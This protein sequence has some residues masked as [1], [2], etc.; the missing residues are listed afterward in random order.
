MNSGLLQFG[1]VA[2][3]SLFSMINPISA[4]P[5]FVSMTS[6]VQDSRRQIA[7]RACLTAGIA[8]VLFALAGS[9][10]FAFF[11]ITV[12]AFQIAGGLLF[13]VSSIR[14]LQGIGRDE[15]EAT[16]DDP[17][18][19]PLGVPVLAGA[20]ALS[21]VM[22]LAAQAKSSMHSAVLGVV[23]VANVLIAMATLIL[24]PLLVTRMGRVGADALNRV[25]GLLTAVIGVQFII[26]GSTSVV[27][28]IIAQVR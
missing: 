15:E 13:T 23:I 21:T 19:V 12:P 17:G 22:L 11:G 28:D 2:F 14:T 25:M 9:A 3:S 10:V 16:G 1:L 27:K 4:A 6:G 24:A 26:N 7:I 18:I 8:L 20:G 5:I